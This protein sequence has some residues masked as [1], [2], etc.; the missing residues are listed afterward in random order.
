MASDPLHPP[1]TTY[2]KVCQ[3]TVRSNGRAKM[4]GSRDGEGGGRLTCL[5]SV[6]NCYHRSLYFIL[7]I[8]LFYHNALLLA[9]LFADWLPYP[10]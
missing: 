2:C 6:S 5:L 4:K 8:L 1:G 9:F 7:L 10:T 3:S